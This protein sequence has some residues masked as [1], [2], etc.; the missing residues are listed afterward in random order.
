M[1]YWDTG[2]GEWVVLEG[3][4]ADT[5][6]HTISVPV[7]HFTEFAIM[8]YTRP[9]VFSVSDL[10]VTPAQVDIGEEVTVSV[11]VSNTGDLSG[12]YEVALKVDD[13]VTDTK[14]IDLAGGGCQQVTFTTTRDNAGTCTITVGDLLCTFEIREPAPAPVPISEPTPEPTPEPVIEPTPEPAPEPEPTQTYWALIIGIIVAAVV[15][16]VG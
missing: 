12:S 15:I 16:A 14:E 7:P 5:A 3:S 10:A 13:A 2:T 6:T 9:A 11:L 1:A 4:V 8:A